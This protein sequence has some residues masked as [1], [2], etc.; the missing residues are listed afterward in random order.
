MPNRI[1]HLAVWVAAIVYFA[2]GYA[3]FT[4]LDGAWRASLPGPLPMPPISTYVIAF[5]MG[6]VLAYATAIALTRHPEEQ[7]LG[8]GIS[9]ALFMGIALFVTQFVTINLFEQRS[10][11]LIAID[12][13]YVVIGFAIVGAIVGAWKKPA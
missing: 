11:M 12:A 4:V 3:W 10:P 13:G 5:F 8:G 9:F 6:V 2:W 7:S 1:N